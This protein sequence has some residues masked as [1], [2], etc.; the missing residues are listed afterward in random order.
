MLLV[1]KE[2]NLSEKVKKKKRPI[3]LS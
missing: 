3:T 1:R 2:N